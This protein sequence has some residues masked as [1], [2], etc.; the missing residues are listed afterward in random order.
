MGAGAL[1]DGGAAGRSGV[2]LLFSMTERRGEER[3]EV[4]RFWK[5]FCFCFCG[6][7]FFSFFG[8]DFEKWEWELELQPSTDEN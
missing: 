2:V 5:G 4:A 1:T 6:L 7:I 8:L 3:R